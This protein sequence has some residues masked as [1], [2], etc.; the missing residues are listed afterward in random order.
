VISRVP[1]E[2]PATAQARNARII[3]RERRQFRVVDGGL[4]RPDCDKT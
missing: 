2:A 3:R 1:N 4:S